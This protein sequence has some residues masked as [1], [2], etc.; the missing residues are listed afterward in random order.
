MVHTC[1]VTK[2]PYCKKYT[3]FSTE[4][5]CGGDQ[6]MFYAEKVKTPTRFVFGG[7]RAFV[8]CKW[9]K[10]DFVIKIELEAHVTS[11]KIEQPDSGGAS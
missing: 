2:C 6:L 4:D 3:S 5:R 1:V 8:D 11:R 9:C 10:K 7:E